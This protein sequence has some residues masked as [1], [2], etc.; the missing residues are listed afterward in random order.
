MTTL[1]CLYTPKGRIDATNAAAAE[2]E[3]L[4][5]LDRSGPSV[6]IEMSKV[7]Y[8]SSAGLRV[9]LVAAKSARSRG[10]KAIVVAP[11]AAVMEVLAM[12]GFDKIIP[13]ADTLETAGAMLSA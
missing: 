8:L 2:S 1:P 3:V 11:Q 7:A 5:V 12:S 9:L 10:G 13:I 6:V 4:A